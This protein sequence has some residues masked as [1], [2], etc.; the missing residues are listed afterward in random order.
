MLDKDKLLEFGKVVTVCQSVF[1]YEFLITD[2]FSHKFKNTMAC[3]EVCI[4]IAEGYPY[5]KK[6]VTE[7]NKFHLILTKKKSKNHENL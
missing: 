2:G 5:V 4:E 1:N 7:E 3:I 6:C